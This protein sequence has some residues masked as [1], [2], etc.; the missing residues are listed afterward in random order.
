MSFSISYLFILGLQAASAARKLLLWF[1][2]MHV[3][4]AWPNL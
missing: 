4:A 3:Q 2:E 1:F